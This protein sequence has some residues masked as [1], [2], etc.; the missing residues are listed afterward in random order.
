MRAQLARLGYD[1]RPPQGLDEAMTAVGDFFSCANVF[2][3]RLTLHA[4]IRHYGVLDAIQAFIHFYES[5]LPSTTV[6]GRHLATYGRDLFFVL[7]ARAGTGIRAP[8]L[9]SRSPRH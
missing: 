3:P 8:C 5:A 6:P 7:G 1:T 9:P 4:K 2:Q